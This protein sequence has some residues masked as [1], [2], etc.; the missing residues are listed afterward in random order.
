[1]RPRLILAALTLATFTGATATAFAADEN[2]AVKLVATDGFYVDNDPEGPSGGDLFGSE[3]PLRDSGKQVGHFHAACVSTSAT[4]N[5][6]CNV[7]LA[8]RNRG[9]IQLAGVIRQSQDHSRLTITG[10]RGDFRG[11]DGY[12]DVTKAN[13]EGSRQRVELSIWY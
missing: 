9:K 3:G 11:A 5:G 8:L 10:G 6:Q 12:A 1:M 13:E 7:T 2:F 4:M